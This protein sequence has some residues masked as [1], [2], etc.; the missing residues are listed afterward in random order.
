MT[1][2]CESCEGAGYTDVGDCEDGV[3]DTCPECRGTG[4]VEY[5]G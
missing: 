1:D 3:T 2:I 5:L 4:E